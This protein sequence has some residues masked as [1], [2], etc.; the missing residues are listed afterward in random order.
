M[1]ADVGSV[2]VL[3]SVPGLS[4]LDLDNASSGEFDVSWVSVS[5]RLFGLS[6][7]FVSL[8]VSSVVTID[9]SGG[10]MSSGSGRNDA[11]KRPVSIGERLCEGAGF[12]VLRCSRVSVKS[13]AG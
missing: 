8:K 10:A 1:R 13:T 6:M 3:E 12:V 2:V 4:V 5:L 11:S 9:G 7:L